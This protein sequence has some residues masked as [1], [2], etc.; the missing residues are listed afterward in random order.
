MKNLVI[1]QK[2]KRMN[3]YSLKM[4]EYSLLL[5]TKAWGDKRKYILERD[6]YSC[7]NCKTQK[8]LQVHHTQYHYNKKTRVPLKPWN[9]NSK[10]L[11]TLCDKCHKMGH[12]FFGKS[13]W[14][15]V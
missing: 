8:K 3:N 14:F 6:N 12:K 1:Y 5:K 15:A 9:Y 11:I 4:K 7:I 2:S 13:K 10:Y